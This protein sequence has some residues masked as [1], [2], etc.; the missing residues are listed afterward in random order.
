MSR[1]SPEEVLIRPLI[2]EES[3]ILQAE[4]NKY[5]FQVTRGATKIDIRRAV[6]DMFDVAVKSVRTMNCPGKQRRVGRSVGFKPD[7]K[8]AIVTL[9]DGEVIDMYEG[10]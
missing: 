1:R 8:K 2:T 10:V 9:R 5:T 3:S 7:W 6:E 4:Q